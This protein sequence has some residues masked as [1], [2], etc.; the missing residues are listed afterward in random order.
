[1]F[2]KSKLRTKE[3]TREIFKLQATGI[4]IG[5]VLLIV[6]QIL[7]DIFDTPAY[8]GASIMLLALIMINLTYLVELKIKEECKKKSL[9]NDAQ[10]DAD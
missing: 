9:G 10:Q 4:F 7:N 2:L 6:I 8:F 5:V 3:E 1:M